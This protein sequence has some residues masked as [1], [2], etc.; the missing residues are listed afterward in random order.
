MTCRDYI[1]APRSV[2]T[3]AVTEYTNWNE[4]DV[5]SGNIDNLIMYCAIY[6][7][8]RATRDLIIGA[9]INFILD[10]KND[11]GEDYKT[12]EFPFD[13]YCEIAD[14]QIQ[15]TRQLKTYKSTLNSLKN[16][17]V[18]LDLLVFTAATGKYDIMK[19]LVEAVYVHVIL[20]HECN[21][22]EVMLIASF[23]VMPEIIL[24][25]LTESDVDPMYIKLAVD[26]YKT[27]NARTQKPVIPYTNPYPY[28]YDTS[29]FEDSRSVA[30]EDHSRIDNDWCDVPEYPASA[31]GNY[32]STSDTS[33]SQ[34]QTNYTMDSHWYDPITFD[35][36]SIT[37][38]PE[39][40][41][42][43]E[44]T[45]EYVLDETYFTPDYT[46]ETDIIINN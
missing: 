30:F 36:T 24:E 14:P 16:C 21:Y 33:L 4:I 35:S 23:I 12:S 26:V 6:P 38:L 20:L 8:S 9:C 34:F 22:T 13:L 41:D 39:Y 31:W 7:V 17:E 19:Q 25:K 40:E 45:T 43:P 42:P 2:I 28:P 29:G 5:T 15:Y 11:L 27:Q 32:G 44:D 18:Y 37:E 10:T 1:R 3:D 46:T